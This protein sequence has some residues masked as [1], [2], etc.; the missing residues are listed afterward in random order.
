MRAQLRSANIAILRGKSVLEA[1]FANVDKG[2][3]VQRLMK[4]PPFAGR[5]VVFGGDDT[6]DMDVFRILPALKGTASR[7][8]DCTMAPTI[9]LTA[10]QPSVRGCIMWRRTAL[11]PRKSGRGDEITAELCRL[12]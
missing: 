1:R 12:P 6:T 9:F 8:A 2:A 7:W 11:P 4:T 3:A 10:P 5:D